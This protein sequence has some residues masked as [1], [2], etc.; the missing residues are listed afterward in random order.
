MGVGCEEGGGGSLS[1]FRVLDGSN[2]CPLDQ[3]R[4]YTA[5][6]NAECGTFRLNRGRAW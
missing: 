6:Q 1:G 4:L 3:S 5:I 2:G